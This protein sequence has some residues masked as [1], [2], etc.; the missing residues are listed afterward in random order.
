MPRRSPAVT[1]LMAVIA[2][3]LL[4]AISNV[5]ANALPRSWTPLLW[6]AWPAGLLLTAP[7]CTWKSGSGIRAEGWH[8]STA[9]PRGRRG[10]GLTVPSPD[11]AA[12]PSGGSGPP[13]SCQASVPRGARCE[14]TG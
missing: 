10:N 13:T 5:E 1:A 12:R 9:R 14:C 11:L 7:R 3:V 8:P 2:L 4:P 6:I